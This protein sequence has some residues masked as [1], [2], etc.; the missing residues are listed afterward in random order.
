MTVRA[1]LTDQIIEATRLYD[2][3]L[4]VNTTAHREL[5]DLLPGVKVIQVPIVRQIS[6]A[7]DLRAL[8]R[9]IRLCLAER[10]D[11]VH[12]VTPKAGLIAAL[13]GFLS[14]IPIRLHT[15][16]G[17]VWATRVGIARM[18]LKFMDSLLS[19]CATNVLVDS[20]SQRDFLLKEGVISAA[21]SIVLASGSISGVDTSRFRPD[22]VLRAEKRAS[23]GIGDDGI[24]LL[25]VGRLNR[26]K[27][28]LDLALV[29]GQLSALEGRLHLVIVGPDE[30]GLQ[31]RIVDLCGSGQKRVHFVPFTTEPERFTA[32]ADIFCL[33]SYREGFGSV[34]I[35]AAAAGVPA[36]G[37]RIY[38]ITDAIEE[39]ITGLLF[40][41]GDTED[42]KEKI[43][44]L[45]EHPEAR[46]KMGMQARERAIRHF[47][48]DKVTAALM[49]YYAALLEG[50]ALPT[51]PS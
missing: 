20:S 9:L 34:V 15:F 27:G 38:G 51:N 8:F 28:I 40:R 21:K 49:E 16:T 6:P 3:S 1:F 35:E 43:L 25:F 4:V 12:S 41:P 19:A 17:Q 13:A 23:L 22:N 32:A 11:L 47:S 37:S 42:L 30:E 7:G 18:F 5:S 26:D 2:V 36:V 48:K 14:R 45:V 10:Y 46:N 39:D 50:R 31:Q 33:P 29:F 24:S 44:F